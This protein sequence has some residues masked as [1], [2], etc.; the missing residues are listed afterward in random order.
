MKLLLRN[1]HIN[2]SERLQSSM[3]LNLPARCSRC[4][5]VLSAC[6]QHRQTRHLSSSNN[7]N[8]SNEHGQLTP[9]VVQPGLQQP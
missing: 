3:E 8:N 1:M 4:C 9:A 7:K 6:W 2:L 5:S